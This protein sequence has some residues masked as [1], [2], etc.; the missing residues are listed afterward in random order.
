MSETPSV[1]VDAPAPHPIHL[2]VTDDLQRIRLTVVMPL[3][4]RYPSFS[5]Q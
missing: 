1:A 5:D 4:G 3:T 2:V